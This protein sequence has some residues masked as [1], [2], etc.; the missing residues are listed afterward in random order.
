MPPLSGVDDREVQTGIID[1][2][3]DLNGAIE[4]LRRP[5]SNQAVTELQRALTL[6]PSYFRAL[7][8]LG[9][10]LMKKGRLDEAAE[11]FDRAVKIAPRVILS[12]S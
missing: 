2:R 9:V 1:S 4:H 10:I 11:M 12:A 6:Y 5:Q 7:N 8:D 3:G